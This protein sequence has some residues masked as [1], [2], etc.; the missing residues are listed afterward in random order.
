MQQESGLSAVCA[1]V[2]RGDAERG[3]W[4]T[5][6]SFLMLLYIFGAS[7]TLVGS[8]ALATNWC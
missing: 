2:A 8:G 7:A 4:V 5:V 3:V 1:T 6:A